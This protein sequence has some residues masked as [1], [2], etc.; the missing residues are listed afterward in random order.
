MKHNYFIIIPPR[1]RKDNRITPFEKLLYGEIKALSNGKGYCDAT[2]NYFAE[3]YDTGIRTVQ[4]A[5]KSLEKH[6][7]V[8]IVHFNRWRQLRHTE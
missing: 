4:R 6:E 3:V 7:Y 8:K 5:L 1:I 2:N